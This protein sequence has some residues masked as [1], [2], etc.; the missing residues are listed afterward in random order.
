M[1]NLAHTNLNVTSNL[2]WAKICYIL[3]EEQSQCPWISFTGPTGS[4]VMAP[5]LD[6]GNFANYSQFWI[7]SLVGTRAKEKRSRIKVRILNKT[8][9][10]NVVRCRPWEN[11]LHELR[12]EFPK[13]F[14]NYPL[15]L[16]PW[17][18]MSTKFGSLNVHVIFRVCKWCWIC[19][20]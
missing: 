14:K 16:D 20:Y 6:Q 18:C 1:E 7:K 10:I 17:T 8:K 13:I 11:A 12:G 2:Y 5:I 19:K 4:K 9:K 3:L 15:N